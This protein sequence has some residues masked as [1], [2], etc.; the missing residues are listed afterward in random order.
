MSV[1]PGIVDA[2]IL[3]YA[4]DAQAPQHVACRAL[5]EAAQHE[6]SA[7][8][9]YVTLQI[10]CEFFAIVT[11]ARR[12]HKPRSAAEALT[13]IS[14]M[15]GFLRVLPVPATAID[16]VRDLLRRRPVTGG[17]IFDLQIVA[18]MKLNNIS[19]IYTFNTDDFKPFS[20]IEPL[21][22]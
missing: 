5:L 2:N 8:T 22:P 6:A 20:E 4:L 15:L 13:A 21:A 18:T 3:I 14:N 7:P 9:L 12:V 11:N 16:E 10:L 17:D 19:R 1:E